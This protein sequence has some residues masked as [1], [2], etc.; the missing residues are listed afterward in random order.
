MH[1]QIITYYYYLLL[2]KQPEGEVNKES[3]EINGLDIDNLKKYGVTKENAIREIK[4]YLDLGPD[5]DAVFIAYCG[6]LD[7]IFFDQIY[8]DCNA[9]NPFNYEIIEIGSLAMGK[10]GFEYGFT[11]KDLLKKIGIE[12]LSEDEKHNA[13]NDAMLQAIEF[14]EIMNFKK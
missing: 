3:M 11:E 4:K 2:E 13:L 5:D 9:N 8:Q 14:C 1:V 7:K 12:E 6:V 10:L